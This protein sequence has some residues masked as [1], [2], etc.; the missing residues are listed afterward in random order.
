MKNNVAI[1]GASCKFFGIDSIEH[2]HEALD[3]GINSDIES[4]AK[5]RGRILGIGGYEKFAS[6]ALYINDIDKFD[7]K[8]F[9]ISK[10]EASSMSPEMKLAFQGVV[11][12]LNNAG[13][14]LDS[15]KKSETGFVIA[16]SE[17]D[18]RSMI[19]KKDAMSF[20]GN[21]RGMTAGSIAYHL[22][23]RGPSMLV[24]STCSSSLLAVWEAI[25]FIM[26][27]Q[28]DIM[29]A[30]GTEIIFQKE[31]TVQEFKNI[32]VNSADMR[33]IPFDENADGIVASEGCGFVVL[34]SYEKAV[35]DGD[36]IYG[37]ITGGAVNSNGS[38][39]NTMTTPN[40]EAQVNAMERALKL[41]GVGKDDITEIEAHG[42]GTK[43][44]DPIEAGAFADILRDRKNPEPV[45]ISSVK[46]FIGHTGNASG[47]AGLISVISGFENN[48]HYMINGF[49]KLSPAVENAENMKFISRTESVGKNRKR[50]AGVNSL[51]FSG[52][53]VHLIVE[54]HISE[55]EKNDSLADNNQLVVI[56][57]KTREAYSAVVSDII[58]ALKNYDGDINKFVYSLNSGRDIYS[59][60]RA[61][62]CSR[63]EEL[64]SLLSQH[65]EPSEVS[66]LQTIS[67]T[68]LDVHAV[69]D[70]INTSGNIDWNEYYKNTSFGK[71]PVPAYHFDRLT[72]W[73]VDMGAL[74][75]DFDFGINSNSLAE[76]EKEEVSENQNKKSG[77]TV[78]EMKEIIREIWKEILESDEDIDDDTSFFELGG[79]SL[80]G[81]VMIEEL[82]DR[83]GCSFEIV[84]IYEKNTIGLLADYIINGGG[85]K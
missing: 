67:A 63:K 68:G 58:D 12:A 70:L 31:D 42:T 29:I 38:R 30:G 76:P 21:L 7:Y 61:F 69:A 37:V 16:Q 27:G 20:T 35:E 36:Y 74:P 48:S 51:G 46:S 8:F 17:C 23:L 3:K 14:P 66:D 43:I 47:I 24:D 5:E 73:A 56:S 49:T 19:E 22:D 64:I 77:Y 44:G 65:D 78:D 53:N 84:E 10:K 52:L 28:A 50:I 79:N 40:R 26:T 25:Q 83:T 57:A 71:V 11:S 59:F 45:Y 85:N 72:A 32:S 1:I 75:A 13:I 6:N 54:N 15:V 55:T 18:Y 62:V 41:A 39:S 34:K 60:R 82:V 9:G 80:L 81:S 33:C 2:L 4:S